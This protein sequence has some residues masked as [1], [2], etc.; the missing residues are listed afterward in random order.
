MPLP[1]T[2]IARA[3][4]PGRS[5]RALLRASGPA[6]AHLGATLRPLPAPRVPTVCLLPLD[7]GPLP[8]LATILPGPATHTGEDCLELLLPGNPALIDRVIDRFCAHESVR[9]AGPGEFSARAYLNGRLT[10]DQAEGVAALISAR[11]AEDLATAARLAGGETGAAYRAWADQ[12]AT[13]LALAEAGIDFVDQEDVVPITQGRLRERLLALLDQMRTHAGG[14]LARAAA[15]D[16]PLIV[17]V[18]DPN[19]GKST[20]FNTLLGHRRAVI[21][22]EAGT[23]RDVLAEPLDLGDAGGPGRRALL[24]DLPGL[25]PDATGP[26]PEAAQRRAHEALA[27]ADGAIYCDPTGRFDGPRGPAI[28]DIPIL[29]V[30]TKADLPAPHEERADVSVCALDGW[31]L[32][33]LRAAIADLAA[34]G[35]SGSCSVALAR[36]AREIAGAVDLLTPLAASLDP[37]G[38][39]LSDP[40]LVADGLRRA[41]DGISHIFGRIS[42]DEVIGRIFATFCVGK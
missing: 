28:P 4:P 17:L 16:L 23:T 38:H 29:R 13:L 20:L 40:E 18:G 31:R 34:T 12:L 26:A 14:E 39:A 9:R 25:D 10:L 1:D 6:C 2:I 15:D 33:A 19:A 36:H 41:A 11:N 24:A 8:V 30:R 32:D 37:D 22:S 21:G 27:R 35:G 42:P 3:T 5:D 7:A